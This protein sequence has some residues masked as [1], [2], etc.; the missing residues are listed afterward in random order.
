MGH[1]KAINTWAILEWRCFL[2]IANICIGRKCFF[3]AIAF[4]VICINLVVAMPC[5]IIIFKKQRKEDIFQLYFN[6]I[7]FSPL[8]FYNSKNEYYF[9]IS[10]KVNYKEILTKK[11]HIYTARQ[12]NRVTRDGTHVIICCD[13]LVTGHSLRLGVF[14]LWA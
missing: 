2:I 11:G 6:F 9:F 14:F 12:S 3:E 4:Y 13:E 7:W 8:L 10:P 5:S 1:W